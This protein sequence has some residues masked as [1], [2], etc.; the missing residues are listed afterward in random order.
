MM[1]FPISGSLAV[2]TIE[3]AG[4]SLV[5]VG[6]FVSFSLAVADSNIA[7][8]DTEALELAGQPGFVDCKDR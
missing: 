2:V 7:W 4:E 5:K 3:E 1:K 8:S 6:E